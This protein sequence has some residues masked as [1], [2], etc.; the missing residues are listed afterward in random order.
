MYTTT[1]KCKEETNFLYP[2]RD[3]KTIFFEIILLRIL[4][5]NVLR[6][7]VKDSKIEV[8]YK[9]NVDKVTF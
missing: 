5:T 6:I 7:L 3:K 1:L 8:I 4:L 9:I 2:L